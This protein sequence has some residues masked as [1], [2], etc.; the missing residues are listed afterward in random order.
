VEVAACLVGGLAAFFLPLVQAHRQMAAARTALLS[1]IAAE[2]DRH[3]QDLMQRLARREAADEIMVHL[4][5]LEDFYEL[6]DEAPVWPFDAGTLTRF[7][8]VILLP[9]VLPAAV[10]ALINVLMR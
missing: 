8:G 1:E 3:S 6:A 4:E 10:D 9:V 2:L 5:S 7:A